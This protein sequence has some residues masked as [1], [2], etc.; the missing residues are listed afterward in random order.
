MGNEGQLNEHG[1]SGR[2]GECFTCGQV[3]SL[4]RKLMYTCHP[5]DT[6]DSSY[7]FSK[8][9][10]QAVIMLSPV[11][12]TST[13]LSVPPT[14]LGQCD[15]IPYLSLIGKFFGLQMGHYSRDCPLKRGGG[16]RGFS[17][18]GRG[19]PDLRP[20]PFAYNPDRMHASIIEGGFY[21]RELCPHVLFGGPNLH[22]PAQHCS[23]YLHFWQSACHAATETAGAGGIV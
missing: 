19:A 14:C 20:H 16:G 12:P 22:C 6:L 10:A 5:I 15:V 23:W 1:R 11:S 17:G 3:A 2:A 9:H 13:R 4:R 21:R 18:S 8:G 7:A